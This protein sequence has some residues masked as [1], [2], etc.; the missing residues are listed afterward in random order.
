MLV[1]LC[2]CCS[3]W[4]EE[5]KKLHA[6]SINILSPHA[7]VLPHCNHALTCTLLAVLFMRINVKYEEVLKVQGGWS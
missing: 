5:K 4:F 3:H 1:I 2:A 7:S 6:E